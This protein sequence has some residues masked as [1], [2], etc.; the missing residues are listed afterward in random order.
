[1]TPD[2]IFALAQ[3]ILCLLEESGATEEEAKAAIEATAA[4][5]PMVGLQSKNSITIRS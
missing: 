4:T 1:M 5:L 2:L 3:R